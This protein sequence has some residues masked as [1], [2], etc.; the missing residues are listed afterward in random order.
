[1]LSDRIVIK[2]DAFGSCSP[3]HYDM[4]GTLAHE[5]GHYL[6]LLHTFTTDGG[7]CEHEEEPDCF[8]N[9]DLICDTAPEAEP[10]SGCPAEKHSC[11]SF[12]ATLKDPIHNYMVRSRAL[13]EACSP[14]PGLPGVRARA[15]RVHV[16]SHP[17]RTI[18]TTF[19]S[20][21]SRSSRPSACA[22]RCSP[23]ARASTNS[24][25]PTEPTNLHT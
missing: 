18:P 7:E 10:N 22:A 11:A 16:L 5:M 9:G 3:G 4:G 17:G 19:A 24:S 21:S 20:R 6:G 12:D 15:K 8:Y 1:M 25:P 14:P 13:E 2:H 23:T